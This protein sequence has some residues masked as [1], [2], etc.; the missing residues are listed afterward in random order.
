[1]NIQIIKNYWDME[2]IGNRRKIYLF[3]KLKNYLIAVPAEGLKM[4]TIFEWVLI[5]KLCGFSRWIII[6]YCFVNADNFL[7]QIMYIQ[8]NLYSNDTADYDSITYEVDF[9]LWFLF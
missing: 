9:F 1:M 4:N 8:T 2:I 7:T 6:I 3:Q 5:A